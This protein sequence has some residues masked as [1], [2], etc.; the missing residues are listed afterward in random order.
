MP[1]LIDSLMPDA[2]NCSRIESMNAAVVGITSRI[3]PLPM[4]YPLVKHVKQ[5]GPLENGRFTPESP[6]FSTL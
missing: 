3:E 6:V 5:L 4:A 2:P 1:R